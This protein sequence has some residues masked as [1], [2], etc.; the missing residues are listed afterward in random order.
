MVPAWVFRFAK[1]FVLVSSWFVTAPT[2]PAARLRSGTISEAADERAGGVLRPDLAGPQQRQAEGRAAEHAAAAAAPADGRHRQPRRQARYVAGVMQCSGTSRCM[3]LS[4]WTV[5]YWTP[6]SHSFSFVLLGLIVIII[7]SAM[8]CLHHP[9]L[10]LL[11]RWFRI[12]NREFR[13]RKKWPHGPFDT[14]KIIMGTQKSRI[15]NFNKKGSDSL[16]MTREFQICPQNLNWTIFDL[17]LA[18]KLSKT[19]FCQLSTLF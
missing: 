3:S 2:V 1:L 17:L 7:F 6:I 18:K 11:G 5:G 19:G 16:Q 8:R 13:I 9:F 15:E 12:W 10:C 14:F 4:Y